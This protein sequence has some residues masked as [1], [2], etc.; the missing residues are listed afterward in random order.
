[1]MEN[2]IPIFGA[3]VPVGHTIL[4][5]IEDKGFTQVQVARLMGT[6][7]AHL[8]KIIKGKCR[9]T[10]RTA[11][12]LEHVFEMPAEVWLRMQA[13]YEC[14][15]IVLK[16]R[17][18]LKRMDKAQ[19]RHANDIKTTITAQEKEWQKRQKMIQELKLLV[20]EAAYREKTSWKTQCDTSAP[21]TRI[22]YPT[23]NDNST[24]KYSSINVFST[25]IGPTNPPHT[26]K[27]SACYRSL[28]NYS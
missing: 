12:Q 16:L 18:T 6:T 20:L 24:R 22:Y 3:A 5:M 10:P 25:T 13:Q 26:I 21:T 9:I 14:N 8:N 11:L 19:A 4:N 23:K 1:M 2:S 7:P 28:H 17:E 27:K 15:V